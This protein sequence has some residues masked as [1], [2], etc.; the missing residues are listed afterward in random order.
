MMN[1]SQ[2]MAN[3]FAE[4]PNESYQLFAGWIEQPIYTV[5][6]LI[7]ACELE[8][9]DRIDCPLPSDQLKHDMDV[10]DRYAR[11]ASPPCTGCKE[12]CTSSRKLAEEKGKH[13]TVD[14]FLNDMVHCFHLN[15]EQLEKT[16]REWHKEGKCTW[17]E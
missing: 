5:R 12:G 15:L 17:R 1:A 3:Y 11:S 8:S 10:L 9:L 14:G 2:E 16:A 6:P 4:Q 7:K 13:V